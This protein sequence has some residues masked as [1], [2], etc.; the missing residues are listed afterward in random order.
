MEYN[1]EPITPE[2][3]TFLAEAYKS[4]L[5]E[6]RLNKLLHLLEQIWADVPE[7]QAMLNQLKDSLAKIAA[8]KQ[9][10][11]LPLG[12]EYM[13]IFR[14]AGPN[15][16]FLYEAVHRTK[17]GLMYEGPYFEVK[18]CYEESDFETEPDWVEPEDHLSIECQ[19]LA[20]LSEKIAQEHDKGDWTKETVWQKRKNDFIQQ[21]FLQWVPEL[22]RQL[23]QNTSQDFYKQLGILTNTVCQQLSSD[24][25]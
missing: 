8:D 3:Y 9:N 20:F 19:F 16:V 18:S 13:N 10:C 5:N 24:M 23:I 4:E 21:H 6:K 15:P 11:L 22:S 17:E 14:G 25:S 1:K 2:L 12:I 7:N